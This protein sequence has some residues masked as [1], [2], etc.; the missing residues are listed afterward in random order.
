ME[1]A[2]AVEAAHEEDVGQRQLRYRGAM[3]LWRERRGRPPPVLPMLVHRPRKSTVAHDVVE[4]D[5][6]D[7][8]TAAATAARLLLNLANLASWRLLL[9]R[10]LFAAAVYCV[11]VWP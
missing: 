3:S 10:A 8:E 1:A 6:E 2:A 9:L 4:N 11:C 7:D 5:D